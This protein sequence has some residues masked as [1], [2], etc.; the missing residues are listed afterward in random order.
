MGFRENYPPHSKR[1]HKTSLDM[2]ADRKRKASIDLDSAS[3]NKHQHFTAARVDHK[4]QSQQQQQ[5]RN[6]VQIDVAK[7][8]WTYKLRFRA[9]V[10]RCEENGKGRYWCEA[11]IAL[12]TRAL[13]TASVTASLQSLPNSPTYSAYT[14]IPVRF[15]LDIDA[16][17]L[18]DMISVNPH[19]VSLSLDAVN[20]AV[21][22]DAA[23]SKEKK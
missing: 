13:P 9:H 8:Q 21:I 2:D 15:S 7:D 11:F 14:S 5:K 10:E 3:S 23:Q 1:I 4:L 19:S 16:R 12:R 20:K 22:V 18:V 6:T 17:N